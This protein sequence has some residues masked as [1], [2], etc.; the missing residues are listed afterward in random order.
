MATTPVFLP[1]KSHRQKSLVATFHGVTKSQTPLATRITMLLA[2]VTM[3]YIVSLRL[4]YVITG[5]LY[6]FLYAN[7]SQYKFIYFICRLITLQ[8]CIGFVINQHETVTSIH[9]FPI[10][11]P[12]PT[13]RPVPSLWV[14]PVHQPQASRIIHQAGLAIRFIYDIIRVSMP[15]F[16]IIPPSPLPQSP[17]DCSIRLCLFCCLTYRVI[18]TIFL[19][20][21]YMC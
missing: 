15:F 2:T 10:L 21:I 6:L 5:N 8:Y 14:V 12:P 20:S 3:L 4:I 7:H 17:K 11:N 13:S 16:Q 19:N 1:G 9:V 18:I